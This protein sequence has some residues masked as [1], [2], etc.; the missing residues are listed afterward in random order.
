M[1]I[2]SWKTILKMLIGHQCTSHIP[3]LNHYKHLI[4]YW[5]SFSIDTPCLLQ[6]GQTLIH[7]PWLTVELKNKIDYKD[8][9]QWKFCKSKTTE[10]YEKYKYQRNK[11]NNL[12][13]RAKQNYNKNLLN[14]NIKN[15]TSFCR[16]LKSIFPT[17]Q[18]KNLLAWHLK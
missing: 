10:N 5:L 15:T 12:I 9:L 13:K 8:V 6:K 3:F 1:T 14:V 2:T 17:K 18:K 16:K 7:L 11:V 4:E